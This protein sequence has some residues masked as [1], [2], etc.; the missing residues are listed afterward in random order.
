MDIL[1]LAHA[2][3]ADGKDVHLLVARIG[4][5]DL[6]TMGF[7]FSEQHGRERLAVDARR[8]LSARQV[9]Q[10]RKN[11]NPADHGIRPDAR[12][13]LTGPVDLQRDTRSVVVEVPFAEGPLSPVIAREQKDEIIS[14]Y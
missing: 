1:V 6:V 8:N 7:R 3:A 13:D 12:L 4:G 10:G 2:N 11:I 5:K 14:A 9:D